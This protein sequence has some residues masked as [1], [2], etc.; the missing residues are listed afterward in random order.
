MKNLI[1]KKM[2]TITEEELEILK[3]ENKYSKITSNNIHGNTYF[4]DDEVAL[5]KST[6]YIEFECHMHTIIEISIGIMGKLS[7]LVN[8]NPISVG[9]YDLLVIGKNAKHCIKKAAERDI[10]LN[11]LVKEGLVKTMLSRIEN[12]TPFYNFVHDLFYSD[13]YSYHI[14]K[15][16]KE[17]LGSDIE[18]LLNNIYYTDC[19][20]EVI[21]SNIEY[22]VLKILYYTF[23]NYTEVSFDGVLDEASINKY[24]K[25]NYSTA[26]LEDLAKLY[27]MDYYQL[28]KEIKKIIGKNFKDLVQKERLDVATKLLKYSSISVREISSQVG[29]EN[30]S[31][32][33]K[34]FANRYGMTPVTYRNIHM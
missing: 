2:L 10:A 26:S 33:Y 11:I 16:V 27:N 14:Q 6:R 34:I 30:Y 9:S 1:N 29:Y 31:Y 32:F 17:H 4:E 8:D 28:S 5:R 21:K 19:Y 13:K 15:S 25:E 7:H 20:Q 24:V 18:T 22:I 23:K 3:R 12:D